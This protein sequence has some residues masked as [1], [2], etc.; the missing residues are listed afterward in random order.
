MKERRLYP[1]DVEYECTFYTQKPTEKMARREVR[2]EKRRR[3][4]FIKI[5]LNGPSTVD[6]DDR[7]DDFWLTI[8]E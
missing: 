4:A 8:D 5:Q 3:K 1:G 6:D 2:V 7:W